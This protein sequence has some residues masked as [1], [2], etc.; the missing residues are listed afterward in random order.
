[1]PS[2]GDKPPG[3]PQ[4]QGDLRSG[5]LGG[6]RGK[7]EVAGETD[8]APAG[9]PA[10]AGAPTNTAGAGGVHAC[11]P[12]RVYRFTS[13]P[14]DCG[15]TSDDSQNGCAWQ[16]EAGARQSVTAGHDG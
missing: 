14:V 6:G 8:G 12:R 5:N 13:P 9:I 2:Q 11:P 10:L 3:T 4:G 1:M 7:T 16:S 15:I